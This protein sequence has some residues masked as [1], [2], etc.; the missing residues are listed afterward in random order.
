MIYQKVAVVSLAIAITIGLFVGISYLKGNPM[1]GSVERASEYQS[2]TLTSSNASATAYITLKAGQGTL[3]SVVISSS[4]PVTTLP[5][6]RI[7]DSNTGTTTATTTPISFGRSN[8][9]HGTYT[10]DTNFFDGLIVEVT[11]G[12]SGVY[13]ITYR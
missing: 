2:L 11:P 12:F 7:Y 10:Y 5:P 1:I 4:S 6:V 13:T 9:T 3:G 8:Q